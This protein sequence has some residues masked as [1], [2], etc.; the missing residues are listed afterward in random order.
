V[1]TPQA[2]IGVLGPLRVDTGTG[3]AGP[4]DLGGRRPKQ[5]LEILVLH[6]D[7]AVPK[8][9][10]IELVW[11]DRLPTDPMRTLEAAISVLRAHLHPDRGIARQLVVSEPAAY[12]LPDESATVDLWCFDELFLRIGGAT[13]TA[14]G[15]LRRE[16][17]DLATGELLADEP[18]AEWALAPRELHQERLVQLQLDHAEDRLADRDAR[19]ALALTEV[20]LAQQPLRERGYRLEMAAHVLLGDQARALEVYDT[21]RRRLVEDLGVT[22][23]AETEQVYLAVLNHEPVAD[24]VRLART[25]ASDLAPIPTS[26]PSPTTRYAR[27]AGTTVAYQEVGDGPLDVVLALGWFSHVE[28]GWEEPRFAAFVDRLARSRRVLLFDRRGT[29]MSDPA[30]PDEPF[31]TRADDILAV[32]DAA[33]SDR[34]VVFG[35]SEGGPMGIS[36]A[37]RNPERIAGLVLYSCFGRLMAT[38]DYPWGWSQAFLDLYL[39]GLDA[40]WTTGRGIELALPHVTNDDRLRDWVCRY[41]RLAVSPARARLVL[42]QATRSDVRHQLDAVRCPTVVLHRRDEAWLSPDNGRY[43]ASRIPGARFE[44]LPGVDYWPW[45]GDAESVLAPVDELLDQLVTA[46]SGPEGCRRVA[47]GS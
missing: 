39:A 42:E 19:G 11:G 34:A 16:A 20:A 6:R 41:L 37:A 2:R 22:P 4:R 10:L 40:A 25:A 7:A 36:V 27:R 26:V 15:S 38:P 32:M 46:G 8:D 13:A 44:E 12:R 33:G 23:M 43:V 1:P 24:I 5:L 35:V 18:F 30:V 9:R 31:D 14:A 28:V 3:V 17:I 45:L 47:S 29:G 21:G